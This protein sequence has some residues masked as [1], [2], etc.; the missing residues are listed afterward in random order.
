MVVLLR[1]LFDDGLSVR[2]T[3]FCLTS[4]LLNRRHHHFVSLVSFGLSFFPLTLTYQVLD[5]GL[6][7]RT[8]VLG[9]G[10]DT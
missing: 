5:L 9:R 3:I 4:I 8:Q 6:G 2:M 1:T 7:L 10:F